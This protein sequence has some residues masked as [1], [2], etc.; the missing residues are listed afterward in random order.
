MR[1]YYP[2][3]EVSWQRRSK[4]LNKFRIQSQR[5]RN[6]KSSAPPPRSMHLLILADATEV[7]LGHFCSRCDATTLLRP[8]PRR[9]IHDGKFGSLGERLAAAAF[10][11]LGLQTRRGLFM[12][13]RRWSRARRRRPGSPGS[14]VL[15]GSPALQ[16]SPVLQGSPSIAADKFTELN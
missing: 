4:H 2:R 8:Y 10:S 16:G 12:R 1:R 15:Q 11:N 7:E 9:S 6:Q 14:P 3:S 13:T 5:I